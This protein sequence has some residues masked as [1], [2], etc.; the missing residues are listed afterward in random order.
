[1]KVFLVLVVFWSNILIVSAEES[2]SHEIYL[3]RSARLEFLPEEAL[4]FARWET[5]EIS[6]LPSVLL[7]SVSQTIGSERSARWNFGTKLAVSPSRKLRE[8][9][10]LIRGKHQEN[11]YLPPKGLTEEDKYQSSDLLRQRLLEQREKLTS[12]EKQKSRQDDELR[13]LREDVDI[14][15]DIGRIIRVRQDLEKRSEELVSARKDIEMLQRFLG[16]V[17]SSRGP[18]GYSSR[19]GELTRQVAELAGAAKEAEARES[20]DRVRTQQARERRR[21]LIFL[22]KTADRGALRQELQSLRKQRAAL[23]GRSDLQNVD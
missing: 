15:S 23:E 13:R 4:F 21:M 6:V 1:M 22:G 19:E 18:R 20:S 3:R 10:T 17:R 5:D 14:I 16:S 11:L 12:L 7:P 2:S 8:Y 9:S